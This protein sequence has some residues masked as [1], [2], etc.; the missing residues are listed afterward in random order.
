MSPA[1]ATV[2]LRRA[3]AGSVQAAVRQAMEAAGW[4]NHITAGAD[5]ALKVN[6]GWDVFLPGAVSAPWVV[7]GVIET[8]RPHVASIAL[9]ES[10]QVVA[11]ADK[12]LRQTRLDEV[13]R[14]H[15]VAWVNMSRGSF[16][17]RRDPARGV[18]TD[19]EIPEIL[20]RTEMITVPVMKTHDKT[21]ITGALKNQWGCLRELR[22]SYHLVL[23]QAIVDVNTLV[24]PRFAVMDATVGL[25]GDGP[26]SGIPK[27]MGLVLASGD[28]VALD[29]V[30]ARV[31]SFDPLAI[32]HLTLA[33]ANGLGVADPDAIAVVGEDVAA[34]ASPFRPSHH[35]AVSVA[36]LLIRR[37]A[38]RRLVF[39]T[40]LFG[41]CCWATRRYYDAWELAVGRRLREHVLATSPYAAQWLR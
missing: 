38:V 5:V 4:R 17:R 23:A 3:P 29:S 6:L 13:C 11:D 7:E 31:M 34:V 1:S 16:V 20:T 36:E 9:V 35:N 32:E 2:A 24:R 28:P 8:I 27:E 25:E 21:V 40:P 41:L 19:V 15:G 39:D 37:S 22:H 12:A 30:A 26:K 14:T 33:A 18:L 10:D